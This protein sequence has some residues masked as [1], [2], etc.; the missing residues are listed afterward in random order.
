MSAY[1]RLARRLSRLA[2]LAVLAAITL[3]AS[4]AAKTGPEDLRRFFKDV[5]SFTARFNQV[6]LD[7]SLNMLQESSGTLWLQRPNKFRWNYD[8][9]FAQQIVGDGSKIW[10]YDVELQQVT[11]R[12]LSGSLGNTPA[13]LLAGQG[14]LDDDFDVKA[15]G[16]QGKLEWMQLVPKIRD[17][18]FENIRVG[19]ENG[20]IRMLEM[21]DGFGQTT[22]IALRNGT[23][24]VDISP[25]KFVFEP[26]PGVDVV[27]AR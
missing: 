12:K 26:P 17:G 1:A 21:I 3:Q 6:V 10:V 25:E 22:R 27:R 15:L 7:E 5:Q 24:N 19:F 23:E 4:G 2:L 16:T 8:T 18:G 20:K 13:I 14:K 9:P 11:V